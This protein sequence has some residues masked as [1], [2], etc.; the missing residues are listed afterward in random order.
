[1]RIKHATILIIKAHSKVV[2]VNQTYD[3]FLLMDLVYFTL[4]WQNVVEPTVAIVCMFL[5]MNALGKQTQVHHLSLV[6][7]CFFLLNVV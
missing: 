2:A 7:S 3:M 6:I 4:D 5:S 1:M